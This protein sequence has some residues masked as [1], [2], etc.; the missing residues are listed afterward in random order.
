MALWL[1][2]R[3]NRSNKYSS[4]N[5]PPSGG[6]FVIKCCL[7]YIQLSSKKNEIKHGLHR[8]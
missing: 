8:S 7:C 2:F 6:F 3:L 5:K 1:K 4:V